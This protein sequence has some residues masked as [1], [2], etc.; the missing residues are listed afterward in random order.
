MK[1]ALLFSFG[2]VAS[3]SS[4]AFSFVGTDWNLNYSGVI[5]VRTALANADE[6]ISATNEHVTVTQSSTGSFEFPYSLGPIAGH[7]DFV[8]SGTTVTDINSGKTTDPF[9]F[10]IAGND[11]LARV[12]YPTWNLTGQVTGINSSI[13]DAFGDRAYEITGNPVTISNITIEA[14]LNSTWV[15][16]GSASSVELTSWDMDREAVPE[17]MTMIGLG[18]VSLAFFRQRRKK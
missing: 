9:L 7:G 5:H 17:P 15:N 6:A 16:L 10:N 8:V 18:A 12:T 4:Q 1:R 3:C 14:F 2:I 13:T 11:V